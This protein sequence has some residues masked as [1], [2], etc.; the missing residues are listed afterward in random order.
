MKF[1]YWEKITLEVFCS[2]V[3]L[4]RFFL[5][6][7]LKSELLKEGIVLIFFLLGKNHPG[8]FL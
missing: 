2:R 7:P 1:F 6:P 5:R 3:E 4:W 8:G